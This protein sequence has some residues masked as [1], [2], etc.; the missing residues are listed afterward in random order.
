MYPQLAPP[1]IRAQRE[2]TV[3]DVRPL[4]TEHAVGL[5]PARKGGMRL[6][7]QWVD[8]VPVVVNYGCVLF[9]N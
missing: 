4:I 1:E 8:G 9:Q 7:L 5:R 3:D 6:E 2:P